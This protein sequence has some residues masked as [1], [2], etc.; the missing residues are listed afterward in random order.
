MSSSSSLSSRR[1][2]VT[3]HAFVVTLVALSALASLASCQ[4][5]SDNEEFMRRREEQMQKL[6]EAFAPGNVELYA[7]FPKNQDLT[8]PVGELSTVVAGARIK[9]ELYG[10]FSCY[11]VDAKITSPFDTSAV[12]QNFTYYEPFHTVMQGKDKSLHLKIMPAR[13]LQARK[14]QVIVQVQCSYLFDPP[15]S[16]TEF[17]KGISYLN[18]AFNET[19]EF[20]DNA[21]AFDMDFF[22][23][24]A[25]FG[26]MIFGMLYIF[27]DVF[28]SAGHAAQKAAPKKAKKVERGT[29]DSNGEEWL[30]G[31]YAAKPRSRKKK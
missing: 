4:E 10:R 26:A 13:E 28:K 17:D 2:S 31:T 29:V 16:P 25:V 8:F 21:T 24:I 11:G 30:Q 12:I 18:V 19:C 20:V 15:E 5:E 6:N 23:L 7:Y 3:R 27:T 9:E 22:V 14:F 1:T